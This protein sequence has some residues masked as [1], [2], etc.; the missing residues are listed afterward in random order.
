MLPEINVITLE[1]RPER[2][3]G[4][5]RDNPIVLKASEK[6]NVFPASNG[7]QLVAKDGDK[8]NLK[9]DGHYGCFMSHHRL[10]KT[11]EQRLQSDEWAFVVEDDVLIDKGVIT[12][13]PKIKKDARK[14]SVDVIFFFVHRAQQE[15]LRK[16]GK[17]KYKWA[18]SGDRFEGL[19]PLTAHFDGTVMYAVNKQGA[20]IL[21]NDPRLNPKT[22]K[23]NVDNLMALFA[24]EKVLNVFATKGKYYAKLPQADKYD[25]D[26]VRVKSMFELQI[27]KKNPIIK[28]LVLF[29]LI[30]MLILG[31]YVIRI[32]RKHGTLP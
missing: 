32:R 28:V 8:H 15:N 31:A 11:L 24:R 20:S 13:W 6:V 18:S 25:S 7:K 4:F 12:D 21:A 22:A 16:Q 27:G 1:N 9:T 23:F 26:T 5:W 14:K 10:W 29:M 3:K 30:I 19:V 2:L 17:N